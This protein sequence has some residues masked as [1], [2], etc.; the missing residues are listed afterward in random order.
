MGQ[1]SRCIFELKG[2]QRKSSVKSKGYE[3]LYNQFDTKNKEKRYKWAKTRER[4]MKDLRQVKCI[5]DEDQKVL[6]NEQT[7]KEKW[8]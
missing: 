7:I 5:K 4:R 6:V 1:N 8:K 2:R 3:I